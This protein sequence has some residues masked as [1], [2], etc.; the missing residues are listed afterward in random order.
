MNRLPHLELFAMPGLP[1]VR[2]GAN[3]AELILA[4]MDGAE[5]AFQAGDVLTVVQ[6]IVSKA[7]GR[8]RRIGEIPPD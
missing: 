4:A 6:K 3:L 7:E 1:E 5:L 2:A 8:T